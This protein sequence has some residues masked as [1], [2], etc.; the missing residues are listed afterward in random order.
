MSLEVS[1]FD[2]EFTRYHNH[3]SFEPISEYNC[4]KVELF[5][6]FGDNF[7]ELKRQTWLYCTKY[8]ILH[9]SEQIMLKMPDVLMIMDC[10]NH[11]EN[12][13]L[14]YKFLNTLSSF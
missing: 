7:I 5:N 10:F 2:N 4:V 8:H 13:G 6:V 12:Y 3:K 9:F 11:H 1:Q 14:L